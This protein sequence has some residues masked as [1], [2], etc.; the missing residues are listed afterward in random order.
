M[1]EVNCMRCKLEL[2]KKF[3]NENVKKIFLLYK[4]S[5]HIGNNISSIS[6]A[7]DFRNNNNEEEDKFSGSEILALMFSLKCSLLL[8]CVCGGGGGWLEGGL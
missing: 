6:S 3:L 5:A 8:L 4:H 2:N 7:E 1:Q